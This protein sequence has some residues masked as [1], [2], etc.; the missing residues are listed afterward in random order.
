MIQPEHQRI[1]EMFLQ[2][3]VGIRDCHRTDMGGKPITSKPVCNGLT[4]TKHSFCGGV[5]TLASSKTSQDREPLLRGRPEYNGFLSRRWRLCPANS[6]RVS[7]WVFRF[8]LAN[9]NRSKTKFTRRFWYMWSQSASV[10][11]KEGVYWKIFTKSFEK[12]REKEE[13]MDA[14]HLRPL[15]DSNSWTSSCSSTALGSCLDQAQIWKFFQK[16]DLRQPSKFRGNF[17]GKK[18]DNSIVASIFINIQ[19]RSLSYWNWF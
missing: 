14:Y 17:P 19:R 8:F 15:R 7:Q 18:H 2:S 4:Y 9:G 16:L 6:I 13:R 3:I 1:G 10:A 12:I 5:W 11:C